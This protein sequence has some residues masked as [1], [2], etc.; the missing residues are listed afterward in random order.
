M[1]RK[2]VLLLV[3]LAFMAAV[4]VACSPTGGEPEITGTEG[5][6]EST[7]TESGDM[8]AEPK[9]S[10]E[11]VRWLLV[12]YMNAAGETVDA[13]ADVEVT[14][15]FDADG[16]VSGQAGCNS[17]FADYTVEGNALTV[18]EAGSTLKACMP[19][20]IMEQEA[21]FIAALQSGATFSFAGDMLQIANAGGETVLTFQ[22]SEPITLAGTNWTASMVNNN[23]EAVT[24]LAEGTAITAN[25]TENG[26][27]TGS[28]GCNNYMTSYT[29]DGQN[30][31]IEPP[32]ST[33]K[34]CSEPEGIMEQEAAF[35]ALLPQAAT[36]SVSGNSLELR[37]ADGALI[38]SLSAAQ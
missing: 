8:D 32:A 13:L 27:L 5:E 31:T 18:G 6:T 33:R 22:A 4:M 1:K 30:I 29:L 20:E 35:L 11:G 28:A 34:L 14:A 7:A 15:E 9:A 38:V 10:L 36:Y 21:A 3:I 25:F 37:T 26:E 2:H 23:L 12:S 16:R 19:D 24:S 17:Y